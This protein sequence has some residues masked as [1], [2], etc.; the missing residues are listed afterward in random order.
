MKDDIRM[1]DA[2]MMNAVAGMGGRSVSSSEV[3]LRLGLTPNIVSAPSWW[4]ALV[5][6][7]GRRTAVPTDATKGLL[8][9]TH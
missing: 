3:D 6:R 1:R 2:R 7:M 9:R 5:R 4:D 8:A